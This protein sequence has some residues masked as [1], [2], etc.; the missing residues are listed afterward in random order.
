MTVAI[1][2]PAVG[3]SISEGTI[4]RWLKKEGER[5]EADEPVV[6]LETEKAT[7]TVP[8]PAGGTLHIAAAEGQTVKIGAEVGH[9]DPAGKPTKAPAPK[10]AANEKQP[11][12]PPQ[13]EAPSKQRDEVLASP[14]A[15]QL[16]ADRD[17]DL[18]E[19]PGTG[20]GGRVTKE[21][22][23]NRLEAVSEPPPLPE[24]PPSV[25]AAPPQPGRETRQRMSAIRQRIAERLVVSRQTTATLTTFNEVDMAAVLALRARYKDRFKEK[26]EVGLGFMSFFVKACV[27]A[28]KAFPLVNAR[29]EGNEIVQPHYYHVGVAVSTEKGLMVPVVRDPDRLTFAEIE[30]AIAALAGKAREGTIGPSDL[31]GGT[32]TITNGGVF[33][34]LLSTPI[35]NP[36]QSA[37]LGMHTIQKR[38]VVVEEQIVIRPMMYLALS[39]DHRLIDGREAVLFLGRVKECIEAPER[40]LL[41]V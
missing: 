21:D 15:R 3:E 26:H 28:L 18:H 6:E 41:E 5:V 39:Y 25:I 27:E 32:F 24:A 33:G 4:A 23:L 20:R 2:V 19:I 31:Q 22:V 1:K 37:I 9:I 35:L 38:P 14:A 10:P 12:P 30:K 11:V 40:M 34:S 29:I 7:T 36:P 8:A 17:L 13:P 16:A